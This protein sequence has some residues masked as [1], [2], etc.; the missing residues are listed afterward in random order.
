MTHTNRYC[1]LCDQQYA[2]ERSCF[3]CPE[4]NTAL[5]PWDGESTVELET[6]DFSSI[7]PV[8]DE[9]EPP[10]ALLGRRLANYGIQQFLGQGGMAR[11]YRARHLTL[12]RPC[13]I[14][15]LRPA[16][17]GR[18]NELADAFLAEA[19]AA[20]SLVHPHVVALH[21]I[22]QSEGRQYLEMEYVNGQSL[23]RMLDQHGVLK[24]LE[25][26]RLMLQVS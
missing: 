5:V 3:S 13:A 25:A 1:R 11:V 9:S 7:S 16:T 17:I 10:E 18:D 4:C 8:A 6:V 20:A 12:E 26:T 21:T 14:K 23:G 2:V 15:V 22:G 24:P 19:R